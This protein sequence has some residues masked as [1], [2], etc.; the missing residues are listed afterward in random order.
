MW[1]ISTFTW[2]NTIDPEAR[3]VNMPHMRQIVE[4]NKDCK[5]IPPT[6]TGIIAKLLSKSVSEKENQELQIY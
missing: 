1:Y 2:S 4:Q 3:N 5:E 6:F